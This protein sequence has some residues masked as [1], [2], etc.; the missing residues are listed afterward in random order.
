M[1]P[2]P[3]DYNRVFKISANNG[4]FFDCEIM[5]FKKA[6]TFA[7][8]CIFQIIFRFQL[9]LWTKIVISHLFLCLKMATFDTRVKFR[10]IF[11]LLYNPKKR[12]RQCP[13]RLLFRGSVSWKKRFYLN[14]WQSWTWST[15]IR[16]VLES[17]KI[18]LKYIM[19]LKCAW[20]F[21]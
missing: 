9:Y 21:L 10:R 4:I 14:K 15:R 12:N 2:L 18:I 19:L 16:N 7:I 8:F 20:L 3:P 11:N 17:Y 13:W 5:V 6:Y 1:H